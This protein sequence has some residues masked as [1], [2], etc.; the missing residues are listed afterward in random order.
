ME[1]LFYSIERGGFA[2]NCKFSNK[3]DIFYAW[4]DFKK[5]FFYISTCHKWMS[6]LQI[7]SIFN[8]D[9]AHQSWI[10]GGLGVKLNMFRR[11]KFRCTDWFWGFLV[12]RDIINK[13]WLDPILIKRIEWRKVGGHIKNVSILPDLL[14]KSTWSCVRFMCKVQLFW[15]GYKNLCNLSH[16][17]A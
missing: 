16:S 7:I 8:F 1:N 11:S 17:L 13:I 14:K 4:R 10:S 12:L 5:L 15:E 2:S 9:W 3:N 6:K